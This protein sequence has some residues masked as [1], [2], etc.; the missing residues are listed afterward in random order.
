MVLHI[1]FPIDGLDRNSA[2]AYLITVIFVVLPIVASL[3]VYS[4][5]AWL[6]SGKK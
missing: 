2:I 3:G 6:K 1:A 4:I 5:M